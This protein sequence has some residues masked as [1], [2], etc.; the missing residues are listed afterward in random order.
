MESSFGEIPIN[1]NLKN[2][3]I[4]QN[5]SIR[6]I[7][8]AP[9]NAHTTILYKKLGILKLNDLY[10]I[11]LGKMMYEY[12][13][14]ILP[15]PLIDLFTPN[16]NIHEHNTRNRNAPHFI[17]RTYNAS[18]SFLHQGPKLWSTLANEHKISKTTKSFTKT[19]KK[20]LISEYL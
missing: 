16:R 6:N 5:R 3:E 7:C 9:Y 1:I 15:T 12:S 10:K 14:L 11:Q 17:T 20:M 4:A 18:K 8:N 13:R 19:F 2:I